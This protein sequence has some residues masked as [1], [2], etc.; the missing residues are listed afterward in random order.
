MSAPN[1]GEYYRDLYNRMHIGDYTSALYVTRSFDQIGVVNKLGTYEDD[2]EFDINP[3]TGDPINEGKIYLVKIDYG[4]LI[5][6]KPLFKGTYTALS[7]ILH[8]TQFRGTGY[9]GALASLDDLIKY[10]AILDKAS[11][12]NNGTNETS[13]SSGQSLYYEWVRDEYYKKELLSPEKYGG[14]CV[15]LKSKTSD[16]DANDQFHIV[17]KDDFTFQYKNKNPTVK[18]YARFVIYYDDEPSSLNLFS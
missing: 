2:V 17:S 10:Q 6:Y 8:K 11:L 7:S 18:E 3:T 16:L 15:G 12:A 9:Y 5:S 13:L 14:V 1:F 4:T